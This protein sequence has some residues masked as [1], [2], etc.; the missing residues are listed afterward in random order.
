M[1]NP[2]ADFEDSIFGPNGMH[3]APK[4]LPYPTQKI[5]TLYGETI[6]YLIPDGQKEKVLKKLYPFGDPPPLG[7]PLVDIHSKKE[8][9]VRDYKVIEQNGYVMPVSPYFAE[10]GASVV[11]WQPKESVEAGAH[12][13]RIVDEQVEMAFGAGHAD[14][15][16]GMSK[17]AAKPSRPEGMNAERYRLMESAYEDGYEAG[18]AERGQQQA[19]FMSMFTSGTNRR[20]GRRP[21]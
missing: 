12:V 1:K 5:E 6:E 17:G 4:A 20:T 8:F 11:D 2:Q 18:V 13:S 19:D 10:D 9:V 15:F 3:P 7:A 14:G 16:T 21:R